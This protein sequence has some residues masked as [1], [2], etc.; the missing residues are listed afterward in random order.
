MFGSPLLRL[1]DDAAD[2]N[3]E[4]GAYNDGNEHSTNKKEIYNYSTT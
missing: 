4:I 2:A 1:G 3:F